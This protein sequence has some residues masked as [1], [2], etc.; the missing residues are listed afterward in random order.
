MGLFGLASEVRAREPKCTRR[1]S[2]VLMAVPDVVWIDSRTDLPAPGAVVLSCFPSAGLAATVAAH[3]MVQALKLERIAILTGA[4]DLPVAMVQSGR[5]EPPVRVYGRK[6][7]AV[8][9]SEFPVVPSSAN[10]LAGAILTGAERKKARLVLGLE[11]VI[12]HPQP[13]PSDVPSSADEASVWYATSGPTVEL[14]ERLRKAG[15]LAL[16]DGVIGGV[17]GSLLVAGVIRA[18]PVALLLVSSRISEEYPDH[19]AAISLIETLDRFLPE[20]AIDTGPL[21]SQAEKIERVLRSAMKTRTKTAPPSPAAGVDA[22]IY[23]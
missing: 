17:S 14:P 10:A 21:R 7:L 3:Y 22:S 6:D 15:A 8:V 2:G 16:E 5:V 9:V 11:G 1:Q 4:E 13:E 20:V 18:V 23:G 19:R 12:P